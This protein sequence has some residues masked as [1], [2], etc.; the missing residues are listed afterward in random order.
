VRYSA[1][2][3]PPSSD[4]H[5]TAGVRESQRGHLGDSPAVR[6]IV[7]AALAVVVL[8]G[9][10]GPARTQAHFCNRLRRSAPVLTAPVA[11]PAAAG[12]VAEE[13]AE[14]A[15]VTPLAI[16]D[17]W[18]ALTDLVQ[19]AATMDLGDPAAQIALADQV[20][21]TDVAAKNVLSYTKD[22]CGVDLSGAIPDTTGA[23]STTST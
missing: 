10:H 11:S 20:F 21:A 16:E 4:D 22:R 19:T 14:L 23:T 7:S 2:D 18:N 15:K 17:D 1:A 6:R 5:R 8:A 13:F 9:C 12:A 3:C